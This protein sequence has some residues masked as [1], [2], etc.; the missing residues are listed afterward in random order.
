MGQ[1]ESQDREPMKIQC[2]ETVPGDP[3]KGV[4]TAQGFIGWAPEGANAA[5]VANLSCPPC[6]RPIGLAWYVLDDLDKN[7]TARPFTFSCVDA[8]C[9]PYRERHRYARFE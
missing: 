4:T 6:G 5:L 9:Y 3:G 8:A 7:L 2:I 1:Q